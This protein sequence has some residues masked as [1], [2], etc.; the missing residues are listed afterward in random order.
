DFQFDSGSH[1]RNVPAEYSTRPPCASIILAAVASRKDNFSSRDVIDAERNSRFTPRHS[2]NASGIVDELLF[3]ETDDA[4]GLAA[5]DL[6]KACSAIDRN[7]SAN[8]SGSK[9]P[10]KD[11]GLVSFGCC[12][13]ALPIIGEPNFAD[14]R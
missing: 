5:R 1:A 6:S 7:A 10:T 11:S 4:A 13:R 3:R 8:A 14:V 12:C 9:L 2:I